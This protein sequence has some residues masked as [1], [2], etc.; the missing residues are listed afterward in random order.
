MT[1]SNDDLVAAQQIIEPSQIESGL[2][3]LWDKLKKENKTRASLFNLIVFNR[4]SPRTDYARS[5]VQKVVEQF[6]CRTLFIAY[7]PHVKIPY[8]K[9]AISVVSPQ[10]EKSEIACDQIDIGIGGPDLKRVPFLIL[11]HLI[12][13][14]PTY[15]LWTETLHPGY[16]SLFESLSKLATRVIFDSESEDNLLSFAQALLH[17]RKTTGID[18]ADLNWARTEEWR[19]LT[20]SLFDHPGRLEDLKKVSSIQLI[21]NAQETEFF[22]HLQ[23]QSLY[24]VSWLAARLN[25]K[26]EKTEKNLRFY[27]DHLKVEIASEH[28]KQLGPG[29]LIGTTFETS[30]QHVYSAKR[31]PDEYYHVRV[32][33]STPERCELPY[34]FVLAKTAAGHSL[35]KEI[36]TKGTSS[37]YMETLEKLITLNQ[38]RL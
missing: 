11:P 1:S 8:L 16:H 18:I 35:V 37:H 28:W 6:P 19:D 22:S 5:I 3:T 36:C 33:I 30:D 7:D 31:L 9:T 20:A 23:V 2:I 34:Q 10:G 21:Y 29:T 12:P 27:F 38:N 15:L 17:L 13:D 4:A 25:W 26:W 14:L 24:F 32:D